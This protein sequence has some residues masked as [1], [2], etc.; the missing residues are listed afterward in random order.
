[1]IWNMNDLKETFVIF[2]FSL[3]WGSIFFLNVWQ[4]TEFHKIE[5]EISKNILR[6]ETLIKEN[7]EIKIT[8]LTKSSA[9]RIDQLF[10]NSI[11]NKSPNEQRS[12]HTLSLPKMKEKY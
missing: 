10:Q 4:S 6:K 3:I 8:I 1:M 9:S 12:I 7:E 11:E 2:I 5:R